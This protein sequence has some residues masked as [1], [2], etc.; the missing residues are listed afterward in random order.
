[1]A[2]IRGIA[3][4]R[5]KRLPSADGEAIGMASEEGGKQ[6]K[7]KNGHGHGYGEL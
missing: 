3:K 7:S 6:G 5:R 1:M 4:G 2:A